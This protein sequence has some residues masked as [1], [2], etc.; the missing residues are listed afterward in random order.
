MTTAEQQAIFTNANRVTGPYGAIVD[1]KHTGLAGCSAPC[2]RSA[3]CLRTNDALAMR[4]SHG[5]ES[6]MQFIRAA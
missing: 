2:S 6:C 1:G 5:G 4:V 3:Y